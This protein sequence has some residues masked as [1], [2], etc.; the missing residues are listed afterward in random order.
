[1][2][3]SNEQIGNIIIVQS[4]VEKLDA[5]NAPEL[6]AHFLLINK[7][8]KNQMI[9]DLSKT[10]YCDSTGLSAIL[11]GNRLCKDTNGS[12]AIC[13]LQANVKKMIEITQLDKVFT[14][15]NEKEEA[16][17]ALAL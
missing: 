7:T 4:N 16:V 12:F 15:C 5:G 10:K 8:G 9:L 3:F 2:N 6:K 13:G 17:S 1:M 11:V 14:I